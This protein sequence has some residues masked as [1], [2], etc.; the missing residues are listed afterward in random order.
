MPY[1]GQRR[2]CHLVILPAVAATILWGAR[3]PDRTVTFGLIYAR[4]LAYRDAAGRPAGFLVDAVEEAARRAGYRIEWR[5]GYDR[6]GNNEA[7][8]RGEFDM[9][10]GAT[11]PERREFYVTDPWWSIDMLALARADS[12]IRRDADLD[13]RVLAV[14]DVSVGTVGARYR[15]SRIVGAPFA[16]QAVE[17]VCAGKA[18]AAVIGDVYVRDI[19]LSAPAACRGSRLRTID[20][21]LRT[22]FALIA[23]PAAAGI[24]RDLRKVL[25]EITEDGTLAN[26]AARHPPL[27][28]SGVARLVD[29]PRLRLERRIWQ[30]SVAGFF[31]VALLCAVSVV[32]Q[33]RLNARLRRDLEA[34][35]RA[36]AA[37]R[38][39][40]ARFRAL[41][42]S[43]PQTVLAMNPDRVIVFVNRRAEQMFGYRCDELIGTNVDILLAERFRADFREKRLDGLRDLHG[44]RAGGKEFPIEMALAAV[45]TEDGLTLAF[46]AD[47]SD[48]VALQQ[49]L[50][51]AQ[52]LES[53][54]RLTGGVAHDFNNLLTAICGYAELALD[55][56]GP[57]DHLREPLN[58]IA[59]A[60]DRA[61]S[62][63]RQLLMF[64]RRQ[65]CAPRVL[66]LNDL[67]GNLEKML[68]RLIGEDVELVLSLDP[69]VAHVSADP[70]HI[71]QVVLNLA[72]NAR[73]AMPEGGKLIIETAAFRAD[74]Q[75]SGSHA[76]LPP[77]DYAV[78][79]VS[80]NGTG[81]T[82][83]V[84][85]H[86]FEPFF[87]TKEQGKGTGLGL[88]TVYGIVKQSGGAI[89][90]YSEPGCGS[91]FKVFL[92]AV[93]AARADEAS[94]TEPQPVLSGSETVLLA[95]D[96]SGVR[97]FVSDV[98]R[99]QGYSVLEAS[100]GAAALE[101]AATHNGPIHILLADVVMPEMGGA[102]LA[103]RFAERHA[104]CPVLLM[105]GY[106]DRLLHKDLAGSLI[107][108]PFTPSTL[109][110]RV[111]EILD[112]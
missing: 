88:S 71:E 23:R 28:P 102:D 4:P 105:S 56:L 44:L 38:D 92:P 58:E 76:D 86:I 50:L 104:G 60:G 15:G 22:D 40:E 78:L 10:A 109:L 13:G 66:S 9:F 30:I 74:E 96:E 75:Y 70:V 77:G 47:I 11:S 98:L 95:E 61:A 65:D 27:T 17:L 48:R 94:R 29:L 68:R 90:V 32:R 14:P 42:D 41:F 59:R 82:P 101:V 46:I 72:L 79:K 84:Q 87:T 52:K 83:E 19:L 21:L 39:S 85:A 107:E 1:Q 2:F 8:R 110:R 108:K 33:R 45:N 3:E 55:G 93:G 24:A 67:L 25:D 89:L 62:L 31:I 16:P 6:R 81:M 35:M 51:Q 53:V 106:S 12:P 43:A 20:T 112:G 63:T 103:R 18:E 26:I 73:D 99:S 36:E 37:L 111:R 5:T 80:D 57:R 64:S 34:R 91:T 69:G 54:G 49:Q 97:K 100:N 7:L